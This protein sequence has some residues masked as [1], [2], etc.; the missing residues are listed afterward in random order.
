[1][2]RLAWHKV[3]ASRVMWTRADLEPKLLCRCKK[4]S[5]GPRHPCHATTGLKSPGVW[6][7]HSK[8]LPHGCVPAA[9]RPK[10]SR[11]AMW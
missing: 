1:M 2:K 11:Q 7:R 8:Y 4:D 5:N 6:S 10:T 9:A 3:L